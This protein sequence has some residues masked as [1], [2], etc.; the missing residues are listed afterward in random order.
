MMVQYSTERRHRL[1]GVELD[2]VMVAVY[3]RLLRLVEEKD[4]LRTAAILFRVYYR[5]RE[6]IIN[7]PHYSSHSG[8]SEIASYLNGTVSIKEG[9]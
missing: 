1:N 8:W 9:T 6:H 5:L 4:D 2:P 3:H 7:R